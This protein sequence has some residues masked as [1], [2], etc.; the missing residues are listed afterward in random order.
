[1]SSGDSRVRFT[2]ADAIAL[3]DLGEKLYNA[4]LTHGLDTSSVSHGED[5]ILNAIDDLKL[6]NVL[7]SHHLFQCKSHEV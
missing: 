3:K 4:H 2:E 1:M 7:H 5:I 6:E